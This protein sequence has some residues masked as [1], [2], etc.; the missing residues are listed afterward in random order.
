MP[1]VHLVVNV[2]TIMPC[3]MENVIIN[4]LLL[5]PAVNL[6]THIQD[7]VNNVRMA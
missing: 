1:Q 5:N 7:N 3:K 2:H 6:E 4:H